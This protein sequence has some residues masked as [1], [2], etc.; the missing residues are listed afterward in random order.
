MSCGK[1]I[2]HQKKKEKSQPTAIGT[3]L[4]MEAVGTGQSFSYRI[5]MLFRSNFVRVCSRRYFHTR[6]N[7]L[8]TREGYGNYLHQVLTFDFCNEITGELSVTKTEAAW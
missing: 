1:T 4:R 7:L 5:P 8:A 6:S 2:N 3:V